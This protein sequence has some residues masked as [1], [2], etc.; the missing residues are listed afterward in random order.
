MNTDPSNIFTAYINVGQH[1]AAIIHPYAID[2]LG[3]LILLEIVTISLTYIMG[4]SD[5]PPAV[6]WSIVRLV[7]CGGFAYWWQI[8]SWTLAVIVVGSFNQL[9]QVLTGL[10]DLT[11]MHFLQTGLS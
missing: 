8:Q 10:A 11:P 7:F 2:L 5:N 1:Y 9:G 6:G 4:D 3:S